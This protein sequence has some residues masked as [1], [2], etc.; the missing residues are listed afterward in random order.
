MT[1]ST[2]FMTWLQHLIHFHILLKIMFVGV[3]HKKTQQIRR[4][5]INRIRTFCCRISKISNS[6]G[7]NDNFRAKARKLSILPKSSDNFYIR[8]HY[9]RILYLSFKTRVQQY[10]MLTLYQTKTFRLV[11]IESVC[12]QQNKC[13]WKIKF[14]FWEGWKT[15]SKK[16]EMLHFLLFLQCFQTASLLGSLKVGIVL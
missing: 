13:D 10:S 11:H 14:F 16:E 2:L 8:Q 1:Q 4:W 5:K 7:R 9:I 12:R 3:R 6:V 15:L